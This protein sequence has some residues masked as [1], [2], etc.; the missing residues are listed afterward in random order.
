[1]S[2]AI[3]TVQLVLFQ[4]VDAPP[5]RR[6]VPEAGIVVT[7][8]QHSAALAALRSLRSAGY[9]P[10]A[11]ATA[12]GSYARFSRAAQK[13]VLAPDVSVSASRFVEAVARLCD[14]GPT[15]VIPGS[16]PELAA[17]VEWRHLLP[18]SVLG[19]PDRAAL[20]RVVDKTRFYE[21]AAAAGLPVPPMTVVGADEDASAFDFP[22]VMKPT[23]SAVLRGD[24]LVSTSARVAH[25]EA[26]VRAFADELPGRKVIVQPLLQ[27]ELCSIAGVMW[28]GSLYA[29][30]QQVAL[31][32]YPKP[33]GGSAVARSVPL[34]R[35]FAD[36][37]ERL[38]HETGWEGIVHLQWLRTGEGDFAID[39]NPRIYGSL[40][41]ANAAGRPLAAVWADLLLGGTAPRE[42]PHREVV[43]RNLE[44]F[45]RANGFPR[46]RSRGTRVSSVYAVD[47]PLPVAASA[48]KALRKLRRHLSSA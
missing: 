6:A 19:L 47:D 21:A 7:G 11:V 26:E 4:T 14:G 41:L 12:R 8:G 1:V 31:S 44:T 48:L 34:E 3:Y 13:V 9:A 42:L 39:L 18:G 24:T 40:A 17:L 10:V 27:G 28:R 2:T 25:S 30:V 15:V 32:L 23:N 5:V 29:P 35:S 36:R 46:L 33:C 43:Y 37:L 38:L 16:E 22:V 45:A 20:A